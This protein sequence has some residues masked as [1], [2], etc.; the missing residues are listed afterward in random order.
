MIPTIASFSYL[1]LIPPFFWAFHFLFLSVILPFID[2]THHPVFL[3]LLSVVTFFVCF[4][5]NNCLMRRYSTKNICV[6]II[7]NG[8]HLYTMVLL[9]A[10]S[11]LQEKHLSS[12]RYIKLKSVLF[13]AFKALVTPIGDG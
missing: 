12:H 2:C 7:I 9:F 13:L 11:S 10:L 5:V 3:I 6:C 4:Y 8:I 1:R